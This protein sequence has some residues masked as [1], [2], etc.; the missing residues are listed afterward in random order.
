MAYIRFQWLL[1]CLIAGLIQTA[2]AQTDLIIPG[3]DWRDSNGNL[4]AATEGGIIK[5]DSLYYLWGMDRSANNYAFVGIN[6]YSSPDLK[7]WTFVNQILKK[8]SHPDLD[9][10]AVVERAKILHNKKTG[11]FVMWM[12]YE[13]HNA[14]K[15]AEVGLATCSTIGG[16]YTFHSHF[17]PLDIDSR[18]I[19][20]YQDDDGRGYL[21]CTTK[22][23]QNVSL[24]ELD[25][26]YTKVVREIYRGSASDDMECE[27]HA[28]IKNGGYYFWLMSWCTGW[29]F[30][31]NHYFYATKLAGPWTAGGMIATSNTHTYESQ[32][33]F[34]VT[35]KGSNKTTFLYTGDRWAV[36]NYSMSRIVL[37]PI[38]VN[39]TRLSVKWYDQYNIDAQSGEWSAGARYFPDGIY[40][41]TA[42]HSGMVLGT[43]S[44]SAVQQ[45]TLTGANSQLWRIQNIGASH[46]K[47]TSV[48]SGKVLDVSG[49]SR[50]AGAKILQYDWNDGYNQKW[51]VID[52]GDGYHRLVSVNTLGKTAEISGSSKSSGAEAVL[53]NFSYKDNQL[54]R[55]VSADKEIISGQ[56]YRIENRTTRMALDASSTGLISQQT[57]QNKTS[58]I[59]KL[60]D[61]YNGCFTV[62]STAGNLVLDIGGDFSVF[63]QRADKRFSQ[64]WQILQVE[65]GCYKIT[66]RF[67]AMVLEGKEDGRVRQS[68]DNSSTSNSQQWYFIPVDP[69]SIGYSSRDL[70]PVKDRV[71]GINSDDIIYDL[72]G[73]VIKRNGIG[74]SA[75]RMIS[76]GVYLIKKADNREIGIRCFSY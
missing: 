72:N 55:I 76:R 59:W 2:A 65:K 27:G 50:E 22:G 19:N 29:D 20:V 33:G 63:C 25:S 66:N 69:V 60:E 10:D 32:V 9:N 16:D 45:Q 70:L 4:I 43:T 52:C 7:N 39:G 74:L 40:T 35:V 67:N 3:G 54:W 17:R 38:E 15:T 44:G 14:Y 46:F 6:L 49:S 1:L 37:L 62:I 28:I 26:T 8:T 24:F 23:N 75:I 56:C 47:I 30:N 51:H 64:Q 53:G 73:R 13:G 36:N 11:Q 5:V 41:I 61:L 21:I 18:D 34:A 71:P 68:T 12:H 31:D 58:Q 48:A 42:K 57:S